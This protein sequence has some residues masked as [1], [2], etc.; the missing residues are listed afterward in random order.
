MTQFGVS[1][2]GL[3]GDLTPDES[4]KSDGVDP[5]NIVRKKIAKSFKT[6]N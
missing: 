2:H 3:K 1:G 5:I 6:S 4:G